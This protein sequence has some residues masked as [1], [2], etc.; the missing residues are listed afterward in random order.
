MSLS[1]FINL[2]KLLKF[3]ALGDI[4]ASNELVEQGAAGAFGRVF[5]PVS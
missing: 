1:F 4:K 3:N 2:A 5:S